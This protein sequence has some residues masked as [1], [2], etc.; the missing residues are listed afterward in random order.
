MLVVSVKWE[1]TCHGKYTINNP[2]TTKV[3]SNN[4]VPIFSPVW[5]SLLLYWPSDTFFLE[6]FSKD[7][8]FFLPHLWEKIAFQLGRSSSYILPHFTSEKKIARFL[9]T[10]TWTIPQENK[11]WGW[12]MNSESGRHLRRITGLENSL[13]SLVAMRKSR[14]G[15]IIWNPVGSTIK[16]RP[17]SDT[18]T[19][20]DYVIKWGFWWL[21]P[22]RPSPKTD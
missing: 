5:S 1:Q 9:P 17:F 16:E 10:Q 15:H 12:F 8:F 19:V 7:F 20:I 3:N 6:S 13:N 14:Y 22:T 11:R 21:L 4:N 2:H 18:V